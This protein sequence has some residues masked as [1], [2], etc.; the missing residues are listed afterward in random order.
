MSMLKH[1]LQVLIDEETHRRLAKTARAQGRSVAEV[2]RQAIDV[3]LDTGGEARR[4]AA[5]AILDAEPMAVPDVAEL[6]RELDG[7]R[8]RRP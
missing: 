4:R 8:G 1:R 6:K 2:V 7:L 5:D 3:A